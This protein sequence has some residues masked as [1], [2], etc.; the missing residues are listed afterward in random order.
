MHRKKR[1]FTLAELLVVVAVIAVLVAIAVPAFSA[2]LERSRT[3]TCQANRRSVQGMLAVG[4]MTDGAQIKGLAGGASWDQVSGALQAD[5]YTAP[6]VMC[7]SGGTITL[8]R[9]GNSMVLTCDRHP[10]AAGDGSAGAGATAPGL[11]QAL[12]QLAQIAQAVD[13]A[14]Q[15]VNDR[16]FRELFMA[17][18]GSSLETMTNDQLL[19][20]FPP[21]SKIVNASP[22]SW[23]G[24]RI[25]S[26]AGTQDVLVAT[27]T[28]DAPS[29]GDCL[30][31]YLMYMDGK[32]YRSKRINGYNQS[33]DQV[34]FAQATIKTE[35]DF[36]K[37]WELVTP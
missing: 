15:K 8:S 14:G 19:A 6:D 9:S 11:N 37:N 3:V 36:S 4:V 33:V 31:G 34:T 16:N 28:T 10:D 25:T 20:Y 22:I 23:V 1:G 5:G 27:T 26:F 24:Y 32:Y 2:S 18:Y 13:A 17:Q 7:P 35:E 12:D 21:D 30:K 29:S